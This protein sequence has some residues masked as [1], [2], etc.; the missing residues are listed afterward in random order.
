MAVQS[1]ETDIPEGR[2]AGVLLRE[3]SLADGPELWR[4]ARDSKVLDV[5]S[6]YS[7]TLWCRDFAD[8]SVVADDGGR[9]RGFVT[10]YR[11][12]DAPDTLF[13]WQVAVDASHRGR[14]LARRML[15]ELAAR[16][17]GQG[18][19]WVEATVTPD[20]A[21]SAAMFASFARDH[22]CGLTRTRLF[23]R[24]HLAGDHEPELL[25]RIGP[26]PSR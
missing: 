10:G 17:G 16:T 18:I 25:F 23:G 9:P 8:T 20:N 7:Y 12:P 1:L 24:E 5:N 26:L 11:R 13:I 14:G 15:D 22:G 2:S 3:P 6:P 19:R 21:P 4:M